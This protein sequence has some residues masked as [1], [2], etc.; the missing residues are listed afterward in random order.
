M[1]KAVTQ[2]SAATYKVL[3]TRWIKP[4][5]SDIP[6]FL[7][8][9]LSEE[10]DRFNPIE[11]ATAAFDTDKKRVFIGASV[12]GMYCLDIFDGKTVWRFDLSDAVGSEPLYD[13]TRKA[14]YFGADD[15]RLYALHARSG[16]K[17]WAA[18][19]GSEIRRKP[20]LL[21]DT[22]YVVNA[23]N[24]VF[25]LNPNSGET[26]WEYRRPPLKGFSGA[27]YS[28]ITVA[29]NKLIAG[30]SDGY[31]A[32]LDPVTGGAV[33]E[34]DLAGEV[35]DAESSG[36]V[37]LVDADATPKVFDNVLVGASVDGGLQGM[38]IDNGNVLWTNPDVTGVTGLA[39][40]DG[41][42]Y[43]ARSAFG[44][45]ALNPTTGEVKWSKA[46]P[47][48]NLQDPVIYDDV[49]LLSDSLYGLMVLAL[50]DG[51]VLQRIDQYD[52]FFARPSYFGGY[53]LVLGNGGTLYAM[54]IM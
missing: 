13:A 53:L 31:I 17:L 1:F 7:I 32:A 21:N 11:T 48:G 27:G 26:V 12:G 24:T 44:L 34:R 39:E 28:G 2:D 15:G 16:R 41:I 8:P 36:Q 54:S 52:G 46:F 9:E 37:K 6:N 40:A 42:V 25:A 14:V 18:D 29:K 10:H 38:N 30:Y 5:I 4:L 51:S 49:M 35:D 33:W 43:A 50:T 45:T 47:V 19:T 20:I 3:R 23:D 22:L